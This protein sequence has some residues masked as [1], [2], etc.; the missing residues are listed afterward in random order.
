MII[1]RAFTTEE[2]QRAVKEIFTS[3]LGKGLPI[4]KKAKIFIKINANSDMIG[5]T[6]NTTDL[7][8]ITAVV[9]FLK[10]RGYQ[11]IVLGDGTSSGFL[12]AGIDTLKRLSIYKLGEVLGIKIIDLNKAESKPVTLLHNYQLKIAKICF[13]SDYFINLSKLKTHGETQMSGCLKN[14]IGCV[15]GLNK[16]IVHRDLAGNI[17][18]L[19]R[20]I[21]PDLQII[22]AVLPMEGLGPSRGI[23]KKVGLILA[24]KDPLLLDLACSRI[25][26]RRI[27]EIPYLALA[28]KK[29]MV[30]QK[31]LD[32]LKKIK[33]EKYQ[34]IFSYPNPNFFQRLINHPFY[35]L[36]FVKVRYAPAFFRFFSSGI[37]AKPM[38]WF[39]LR[40]DYFDKVNAKIEKIEIQTL[41]V[42]L[43]QLNNFCPMSLDVV[44]DLNSKKCIHCLYCYFADK[45]GSLKLKGELGHLKYQVQ[46]YK[47]IIEEVL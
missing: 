38:Y 1:I 8:L 42:E 29:K 9:N 25:M 36:F 47:R 21:E 23:P 39:G 22:D 45:T 18:E 35:R 24:D 11:N 33:V 27:K 6:G 2:I 14:L 31:L 26:G 15:V 46:K 12:N 44:R 43:K 32:E 7:R 17:L 34:Q 16:Q 5:L 3:R 4:Q 37:V 30:G 20:I 41:R 28:E 13:E 10:H 40:Q 19:N